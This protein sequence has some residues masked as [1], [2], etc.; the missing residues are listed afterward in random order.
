V[1]SLEET[2][3]WTA[4]DVC[5][6]IRS[7]LPPGWQLERALKDGWHSL[8]VRDAEGVQQWF[9]EHPDPKLVGLDA[10]GWLKLRGYRVKNPAWKPREQEVPHYQ[11]QGV[12]LSSQPDPADLDPDEINAVYRTSR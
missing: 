2:R 9:G 1:F 6:R 11:P 7:V 5:D 3:T 8:L 12:V 4:D 10:L